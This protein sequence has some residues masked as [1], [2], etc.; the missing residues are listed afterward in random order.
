MLPFFVNEIKQNISSPPQ[1]GYE[2]LIKKGMY[3]HVGMNS[4]L[5]TEKQCQR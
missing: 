2:H 1:T 5:Y 4:I 3:L